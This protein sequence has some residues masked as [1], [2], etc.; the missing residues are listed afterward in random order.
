VKAEVEKIREVNGDK[1]RN[2]S[3]KKSGNF[4]FEGNPPVVYTH[5]TS[6]AGRALYLVLFIY[7]LS[8]QS[9]LATPLPRS[10]IC[11]FTDVW[12]QTQRAAVASRR[13]TNISL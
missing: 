13:A 8:D 1:L 7:Y 12:I 9:V 11:F 5:F 6:S 2:I 10:P 4:L 3:H